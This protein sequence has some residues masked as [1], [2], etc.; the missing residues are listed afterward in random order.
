MQGCPVSLCR[1][2]Q[3]GRNSQQ[4]DSTLLTADQVKTLPAP[5]CPVPGVQAINNCSFV[6][7]TGATCGQ[8]S[9]DWQVVGVQRQYNDSLSGQSLCQDSPALCWVSVPCTA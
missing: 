3:E 9:P 7:N 6:Q 5:A 8:Q 4:E 2:S 1:D